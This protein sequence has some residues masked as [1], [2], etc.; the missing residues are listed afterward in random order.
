MCACEKE[1]DGGREGGRVTGQEARRTEVGRREKPPKSAF[2]SS[3]PSGQLLPW[4]LELP[5]CQG[6][7]ADGSQLFWVPASG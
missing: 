4:C 1:R 7:P 2:T 5:R 3:G 6:R